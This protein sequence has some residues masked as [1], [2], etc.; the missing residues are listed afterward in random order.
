M[1][2]QEERRE[3]T[4]AAIVDAALEAFGRNGYGHVS[5]DQIAIQAGVAKGAV[6][7][8]FASKD[9]L[10]EAVLETVSAAILAEVVAETAMVQDFRSAI[11][12]GNR[13]FF[14][15][16]ADPVRSKIFLHDGLAVLGWERWRAIDQRN[17]GA[18]LKVAFTTA[19]D[20]SLIVGRDPDIL[21]SILL[22]AV[23]EAAISSAESDDFIGMANKYADA[24][25][26]MIG[27][28]VSNS[29]LE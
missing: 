15:A 16:C 25:D 23:T 20:Q 10:F 2:K 12:I 29:S 5:V 21:V 8:H 3:S 6:Y 24:I 28:W 19:I 27:G 1:A 26:S 7:H 4:R 13:A 11:S 9:L 14:A 18:L 17:F 22:G